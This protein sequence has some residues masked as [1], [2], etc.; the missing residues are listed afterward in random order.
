MSPPMLSCTHHVSWVVQESGGRH[1]CLYCRALVTRKDVY[2]KWDDLGPD[3][4]AK[5]TAH[6]AATGGP[7]GTKPGGQG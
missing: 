7:A 4:Q 6:E 1:R 5:W 3:F 2:P